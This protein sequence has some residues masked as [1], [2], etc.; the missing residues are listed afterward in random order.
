VVDNGST[1]GTQEYIKEH[2]PQTIF[3]QSPK[4]LGFGKANN[5]GLEYA[6]KHDYDYVYLLNQDAWIFPGTIEK[7]VEVQRK[8]SEY[9]ILSPMQM[10]GNMQ[11]LDYNFGCCTCA[12]RSN[13]TLLSD[14]YTNNVQDVYEVEFVM[15]AHWL[16]SS[17]C[18]KKIGGFS[19]SFPHYGEDDNYIHRA[20]YHGIKAGIV[21]K[22]QAVHDRAMRKTSIKKDMYFSCLIYFIIQYSN[23]MQKKFPRHFIKWVFNCTIMTFK[24]HSLDP[25]RYAFNLLTS[26]PRFRMNLKQSKK[27]GSIF[28]NVK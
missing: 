17:D 6:L 14:I 7:L 1:D 16:I 11:Y 25:S 24:Y 21:P 8:Y 20:K 22:A 9:G 18:L 26:F 3:M 15:A 27:I 10:Q 19:P 12:Y 28:L 5:Y 4:N 23:P 13:D 2:F